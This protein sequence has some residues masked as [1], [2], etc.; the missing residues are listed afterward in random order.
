MSVRMKLISTLLMLW[1]TASMRDAGMHQTGLIGKNETPVT[2]A[3]SNTT[4]LRRESCKADNTVF[5]VSGSES[6]L[7]R[8]SPLFFMTTLFFNHTVYLGL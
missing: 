4:K 6:P 2:G 7:L 5:L 8:V 1:Q 3:K